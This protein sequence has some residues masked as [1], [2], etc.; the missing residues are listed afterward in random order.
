MSTAYVLQIGGLFPVKANALLKH[1]IDAL[2]RARH[3]TRQDLARWCRRSPSWLAKIFAEE[4]RELPLKYLDRVG[5]FFGLAAYQLFQPG[6]SPMLER[7]KGLDRRSGKDRRLSALN[8]QVRESVSTVIA[9]LKPADVADLIRL[10][11]LSDESRATL[12]DEAQRL[13]RSEQQSAASRRGRRTAGK[14]GDA[15]RVRP[16]RTPKRQDETKPP[17]DPP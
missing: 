9:T 14:D 3:Q 15:P 12:R 10:R 7:R 8:H 6:I 5:D 17:N 4:R 11:A 13:E 1:N 16:F 2:L